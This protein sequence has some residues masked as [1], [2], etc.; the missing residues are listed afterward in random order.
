MKYISVQNMDATLHMDHAIP[1]M[2]IGLCTSPPFRF[3]AANG[4][5]KQHAINGMR[6]QFSIRD[7]RIMFQRELPHANDISGQHPTQAPP[8]SVANHVLDPW[9]SSG[10]PISQSRAVHVCT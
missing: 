6:N 8:G 5:N 2:T 4:R 9:R 7:A 10:G 1:S 3:A